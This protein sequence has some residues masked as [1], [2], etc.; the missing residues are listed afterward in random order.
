MQFRQE[1]PVGSVE[2][3]T[4]H[5][6]GALRPGRYYNPSA[7]K[8]WLAGRS[9]MDLA[10]V[11]AGARRKFKDSKIYKGKMFLWFVLTQS[12]DGIDRPGPGQDF[13][14]RLFQR[15]LNESATGTH[16]H[17]RGE[18]PKSQIDLWG[19][20]AGFH[21]R[22]LY[23]PAKKEAGVR[24]RRFS[25]KTTALFLPGEVVV[26]S[27]IAS[28]SIPD[29]QASRKGHATACANDMNGQTCPPRAVKEKQS[30]DNPAFKHLN[31]IPRIR[32]CLERLEAKGEPK[33]DT[34][35]TIPDS[36]SADQEQAAPAARPTRLRK[37]PV[38]P[39]RLAAGHATNGRLP[40]T[41]SVSGCA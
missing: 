28:T 22:F 32:E 38:S 33:G 17:P 19:E 14:P 9:L 26:P 18:F 8:E 2:V 35:V 7:F 12:S 3:A 5:P 11:A 23:G 37:T 31:D 30:V 29:A 34:G 27:P 21:L 41:N 39:T 4:P 10:R 24:H 13:T 16:L 40:S 20:Q 36:S 1:H 15:F 6:S 25:D